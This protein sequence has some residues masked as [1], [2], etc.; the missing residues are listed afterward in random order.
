[1]RSRGICPLPVTR[2]KKPDIPWSRPPL[3]RIE[4]SVD[5]SLRIEDHS[6]G[7]GMVLCDNEGRFLE[8]RESPLEAKLWACLECLGLSLQF[9][10]LPVIVESEC[11]QLVEAT[12]SSPQKRAPLVLLI[13]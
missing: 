8:D 5:G 9:S 7:T 1:L 13:S 4:L 10:N 11:M 3:G 6:V 2:K 12:N